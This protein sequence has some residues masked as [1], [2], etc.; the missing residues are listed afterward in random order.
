MMLEVLLVM[1]IFHFFFILHEHEF[2]FSFNIV[3]IRVT[4]ELHLLLGF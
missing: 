4:D 2:T 3:A 1:G